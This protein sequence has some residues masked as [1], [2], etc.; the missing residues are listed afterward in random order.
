ML[1]VNN[2]P[3]YGLVR[4]AL[5]ALVSSS[6]ELTLL[7]SQTTS[8]G[9]SAFAPCRDPFITRL[10]P[11]STPADWLQFLSQL[12][13]S[14]ITLYDLAASGAT[15]NNSVISAPATDFVNQVGL[16]QEWFGPEGTYSTSGQVRFEA[17]STLYS[18][19]SLSSS[20]SGSR[21]RWN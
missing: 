18:A 2:I 14:P 20:R 13:A 16:W 12:G 7:L 8:G 6:V 4:L 11:S 5:L 9:Y 15:T 21:S 17:N 1:G 19:S 3:G 10:T